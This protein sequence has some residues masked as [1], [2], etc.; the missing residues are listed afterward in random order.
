MFRHVFVS[1]SPCVCVCVCVCDCG[2]ICANAVWLTHGSDWVECP[3]A[4]AWIAIVAIFLLLVQ[5]MRE[6]EREREGCFEGKE[7]LGCAV[8]KTES[9]AVSRAHGRGDQ[10]AAR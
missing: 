7:D 3:D 6:G 5:N 2:N 10:C 4:L 9:G 1:V 8:T